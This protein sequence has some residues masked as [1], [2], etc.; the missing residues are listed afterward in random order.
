[1]WSGE[2]AN[3]IEKAKVMNLTHTCTVQR[4]LSGP[5][6]SCLDR[7]CYILV[8]SKSSQKKICRRKFSC[9]R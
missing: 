4:Q 5:A 1:M 2:F 7:R 6:V 8:M 9:L 3:V